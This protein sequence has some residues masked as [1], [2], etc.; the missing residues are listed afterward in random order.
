MLNVQFLPFYLFLQCTLQ[1]IFTNISFYNIILLIFF[2]K[3]NITYKN[4]NNNLFKYY[5]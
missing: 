1:N 5:F 4:S 3:Y 2:F